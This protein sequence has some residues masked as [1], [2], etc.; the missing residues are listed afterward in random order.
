MTSVVADVVE[1]VRWS[2][3]RLG[4]PGPGV[5]VRPGRWELLGTRVRVS[6]YDANRVKVR[7]D[8]GRLTWERAANLEV[9]P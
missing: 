1:R 4:A 5:E 9:T 2:G 8:N 3:S 7:W 6:R